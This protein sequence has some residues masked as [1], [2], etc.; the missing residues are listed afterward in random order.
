MP[1][2]DRLGPP[3]LIGPALVAGAGLIAA[4]LML[5]ADQTNPFVPLGLV[6]GFATLALIV[7]RP[8]LGP[9]LGI[10]LAA[11]EPF[12]LQFA[13]LA[14][15]PAEAVFAAVGATWV[16]RRLLNGQLP[17]LRTPLTLP[18]GL[19]LVAMVPGALL[20]AD[21][22]TTIKILVNWTLFFLMFQMIAAEGSA[23]YV[24]RLMFVLVIVGGVVGII[25]AVQGIAA[26][27]QEIT[28]GPIE[29]RAQGSFAQPNILATFLALALPATLVVG[30]TGPLH[31]RPV[32]LACFVTV[33]AG[34]SLSLSRGGLFAAMGALV[35]LL[36]LP[37]FRRAALALAAVFL[38]IGVVAGNPFGDV[39]QAGSLV[40]RL[41]S[42]ES[43]AQT[44]P[45]VALWKGTPA[46]IADHPFFGVGA[47]QFQ[48]V[49]PRYR[50][51]E[52][53]TYVPFEHAHNIVLAIASE[54]GL[55]GLAAL[56]WI[57]F[58]T[59]PILVK[60]VR[61]RRG[62]DQGMAIAIAGGLTALMVQGLVDFT[63]RSNLI[64]ATMFVLLACGVI[65]SRYDGEEP[66]PEPEPD[67]LPPPAVPGAIAR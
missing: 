51:I 62:L 17:V 6:A 54:Q 4:A 20:G 33:C 36:L 46:V 35:I 13:G 7:W 41:Q 16:A 10:A 66:E 58:V 1:A 42:V 59:V 64:A 39:Q 52:P 60:A 3:P 32:A 19:L 12:G 21:P 27:P 5:I 34:L 31:R 55:I 30:L 8:L 22:A 67:E 23:A 43:S 14:L 26:G 38:V 61:I 28:Q 44:N 29:G 49:A 63:I 11:L 53:G 37:Q 18:I 48:T 24:R 65:L 40:E 47:G 2:A 9:L 25:A 15:S 56:I 50:L 45:R 57:V